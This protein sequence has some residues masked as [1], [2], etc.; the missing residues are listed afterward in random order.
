MQEKTLLRVSL[1]TS[2]IGLITLFFISEVF[3]TKQVNF[4]STS[5]LDNNIQVYGI[6]KNINHFEKN[7][8]IEIETKQKINIVLFEKF[9]RPIY[10]GDYISVSGE[11]KQYKNEFEILAEEI[12]IVS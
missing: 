8:L 1:I 9:T 3:E 12:K 7:T 5:D 6:I 11:L 4:I 2:I 10:V